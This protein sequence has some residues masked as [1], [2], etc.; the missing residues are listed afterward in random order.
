M[1][2]TDKMKGKGKISKHVVLVVALI[3][4]G[5]LI[6]AFM[7]KFSV[8]G[9]EPQKRMVEQKRAETIAAQI[10][11]DQPESESSAKADIAERD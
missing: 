4:V 1:A 6:I 9:D 7:L 3:M 2:D 8:S 10:G 11:N 5:G